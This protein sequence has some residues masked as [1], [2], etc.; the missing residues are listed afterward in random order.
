MPD[1]EGVF[2]GHSFYCWN[3]D[4]KVHQGAP[5]DL[6]I[7]WPESKDRETY[8]FDACTACSKL[9]RAHNNKFENEQALAEIDAHH[10]AEAGLLPPQNANHAAERGPTLPPQR[11]STHG[12]AEATPPP[13]TPGAAP[14]PQ[15]DIMNA[16]AGALQ[17]IAQGQDRIIQLLAPTP[18]EPP[19]VKQKPARKRAGRAGS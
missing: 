5:P 6:V 7:I 8:P 18:Q 14:A 15:P 1:E 11:L 12:V 4:K 2:E 17:A 13:G 3:C 10:K 16:I 9:I 19:D